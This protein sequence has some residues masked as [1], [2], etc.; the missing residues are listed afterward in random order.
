MPLRTLTFLLLALGACASKRPDGAYEPLYGD[1]AVVGA[2]DCIGGFSCDSDAK[3][4]AGRG[5]GRGM[6]AKT[7]DDLYNPYLDAGIPLAELLGTYLMRVDYYSTLRETDTA[8]GTTLA[9]K[10]RV[11]NLFFTQITP[12]S[13][14]LIFAGEQLCFQNSVHLCLDPGGCR[15]W[16]TTYADEVPTKIQQIYP[17]VRGYRVDQSTKTIMAAAQGA[18]LRLGY[19]DNAFSTLDVPKETTDPRVW[20]LGPDDSR[21]LGVAT[22]LRGSV[23]PQAL[24]F[25][26]NC[27]VDSVQKFATAFTVT[28]PSLDAASL[29]ARVIAVN[30][31][32]SAAY[33][34]LA[35]GGPS[36]ICDVTRLRGGGGD[37]KELAFVR[38]Q[39][40]GLT[41]CPDTAMD[42]EAEFQLPESENLDPPNPTDP[43]VP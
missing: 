35:I 34:L 30:T 32:G 3:M 8:T 17:V 39:R 33:P 2:D 5:P 21:L 31:T 14:Q 28:L 40:T 37:A 4:D 22:Q 36:Q 41:K 7:P 6:D 13:D 16:T 23:G 9:L 38:F 11:S 1:G 19:D 12:G 42:Y 26:L 18:V 25:K 10:N 24:N 15:N 20:H 27:E 29:A 43:L